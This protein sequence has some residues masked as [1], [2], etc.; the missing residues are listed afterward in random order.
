MTMEADLLTRANA[1]AGLSPL[2][3]RIA[4]F[5]RPR[6]CTPEFPAMVLTLVSPGREWTHGGPDGLDRA[7]VQMD[8]Y[9]ESPD[10]LRALFLVWRAELETM[11]HVDVAGTRFHPAALDT[12]RDMPPEDLTDGTRIFRVSADFQFFH[13]AL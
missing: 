10:Q 11:P 13:E 6:L 7:R 12:Q 8:F 9:G 3:G 4:W 1:V 5:E 2:G